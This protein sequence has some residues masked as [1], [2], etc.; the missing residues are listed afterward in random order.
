[1]NQGAV[2]RWKL[3]SGPL[4]VR[5]FLLYDRAQDCGWTE[6]ERAEYEQLQRE[7]QELFHRFL[8]ESKEPEP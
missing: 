1:M 6:G 8:I 5:L 4:Y 2:L 3:E 7:T